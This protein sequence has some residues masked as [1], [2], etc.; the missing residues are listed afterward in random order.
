MHAF[1]RRPRSTAAASARHA[2]YLSRDPLRATS[3]EIVDAERDIPR[4]RTLRGDARVELLRG[5]KRLGFSDK[6]ILEG[7]GAAGKSELDV[8]EERATLG[9]V[10]VFGRVDTCAAE[11]PGTTPYLYAT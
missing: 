2:R 5:L 8:L 3:R 6:Q 4:L 10:P 1:G 11:I 9:V 7:G